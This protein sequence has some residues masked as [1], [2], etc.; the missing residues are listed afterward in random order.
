MER[1]SRILADEGVGA[2]PVEVPILSSRGSLPARA[3]A[4]D[5]G[6]RCPPGGGRERPVKRRA[7]PFRRKDELLKRL[8]TGLVAFPGAGITEN[9]VDKA[10]ELGVPVPRVNT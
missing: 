9:L 2:A 10:H 4:T 7:A 8:P 3:L 6:R 1:L 5:R